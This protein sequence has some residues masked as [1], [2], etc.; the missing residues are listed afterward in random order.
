MMIIF[1]NIKIYYLSNLNSFA[2]YIS[3]NPK[4]V[5]VFL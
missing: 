1:H 3:E 5:R 4:E 2:N